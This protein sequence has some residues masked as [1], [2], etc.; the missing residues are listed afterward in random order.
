MVHGFGISF[1]VWKFLIPFLRPHFT[2]IMVELPGIGRSPMPKPGQPYLDQAAL[3][4]ENIRSM[5]GIERWSI[6]SY[7]SGSRAAERYINLF[8]VHVESAVFL[9]PAQISPRKAVSLNIAIRLDQ[10]IPQFG[11]WVLSGHR[12]KFLIDLLGF[13]L[14]KD[15]LSLNWFTEISSQ[16][17]DILKETLRSLPDGGKQAFCILNEI[18][19]LFIWGHEDLI[20]DA[21]H[22]RYL[23]DRM[24]HATHSAPQTA[25]QKVSDIVLPFL[26]SKNGN[27]QTS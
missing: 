12:L 10:H 6:F 3:G 22:K 20:V 27:L 23:R 2:L 26:L 24:I 1:N 21:P 7:S 17:L 16:P 15:P 13:N 5:L 14:K 18:S 19:T 25:A 8:P 11:N 9:C 4:L